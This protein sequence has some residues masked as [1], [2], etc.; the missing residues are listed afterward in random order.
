MNS[1]E[2]EEVP[3]CGGDWEEDRI[4][5]YDRLHPPTEDEPVSNYTFL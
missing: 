1:E 4:Q 5:E 3:F 2:A